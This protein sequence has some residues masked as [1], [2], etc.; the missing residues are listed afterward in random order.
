[1]WGWFDVLMSRAQELTAIFCEHKADILLRT[2][3]NMTFRE[4]LS[5]TNGRLAFDVN[6]DTT[7]YDGLSSPLSSSGL[8]QWM[9]PMGET[10]ASA[11]QMLVFNFCIFLIR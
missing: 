6:W 2:T 5:P 7:I 8:G 9:T 4:E 1:M 11:T 3:Y 10:Q